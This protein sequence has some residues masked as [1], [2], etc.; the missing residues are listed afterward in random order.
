MLRYEIYEVS[1]TGLV[2]MHLDPFVKCRFR[3]LSAGLYLF[4][5]VFFL[6]KCRFGR[7]A[8]GLARVTA[9]FGDLSAGYAEIRIIKKEN[10]F[11][12]S[13]RRLSELCLK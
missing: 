6:F 2:V 4:D 5:L 11:K 9:G 12:F 10:N 7:L 3:R 1:V 8:A 13:R